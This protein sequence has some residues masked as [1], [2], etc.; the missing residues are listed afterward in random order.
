MFSHEIIVKKSINIHIEGKWSKS[1]D[2]PDKKGKIG[3]LDALDQCKLIMNM[4]SR[5]SVFNHLDGRLTRMTK[6]N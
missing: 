5:K 6:E 1:W 3:M 4:G 2:Y